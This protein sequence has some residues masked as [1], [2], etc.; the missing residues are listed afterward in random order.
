MRT[1]AANTVS[2]KDARPQPA[3]NHERR[4][5]VSHGT[6][7]GI[8]APTGRKRTNRPL[9]RL[10][11]RHPRNGDVRNVPALRGKAGVLQMRGQARPSEPARLSGISGDTEQQVELKLCGNRVQIE[12]MPN[13]IRGWP[14]EVSAKQSLIIAPQAYSEPSRLG[15][16]VA[17]G[18]GK[19]KDGSQHVFE[20]EIGDLVLC[21]RYP[22]SGSTAK[23]AG[24]SYFL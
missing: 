2:Q 23:Y 14:L 1:N 8:S 21:Q 24:K 15:K 4:A 16:V 22:Q 6:K 18:D 9:R 7:R 17:I 11:A 10:Q 5:E 13:D 19:L 3:E 12:S 20:V